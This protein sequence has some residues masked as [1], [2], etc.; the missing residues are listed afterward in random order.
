[1]KMAEKKRKGVYWV[2]TVLAVAFLLTPQNAMAGELQ[3]IRDEVRDPVDRSFSLSFGGGKSEDSS[4]DDHRAR[5]ERAREASDDSL[6]DDGSD[7]AGLVLLGG[8]LAVCVVTAPIHVPC[9]LLGDD[10]ETGYFPKYP[11]RKGESCLMY[12]P[13]ICDWSQ[14]PRRYSGRIRMEYCENYR[15]LWRAGG[16]IQFETAS[17]LG[18][19]TE[20]HR[21]EERLGGKQTDSLWLGDCNFTYRFAQSEKGR[22][23][24]RAW[25]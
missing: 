9:T 20:A 4:C 11:Y 17:R 3:S 7:D 15:D 10:G 5:Y 22:V 24:G 23:S 6:F 18:I 19:D 1:M 14:Q 21:F 12:Q 13:A 2:V 25:L 16:Q 8:I